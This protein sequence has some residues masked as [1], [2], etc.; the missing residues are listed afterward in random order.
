MVSA[1]PL[2]EANHDIVNNA[3]PTSMHAMRCN[4][5]TALGSPPGALVYARDVFLNVPLIADWKTIA[6]WH[7]QLIQENLRK[8]SLKRW[9]YEYKVGDKILKTIGVRTGIMNWP[10]STCW[11]A[12]FFDSLRP[13]GASILAAAYLLEQLGIP[14]KNAAT[15]LL[16]AMGF[17]PKVIGEKLLTLS[18]W[19]SVKRLNIS[20]S[21]CLGRVM[22]CI[23]SIF[24]RIK[25]WH[26]GDSFHCRWSPWWLQFIFH[27]VLLLPPLH[28]WVC[29][30]APPVVCVPHCPLFC[31]LFHLLLTTW[32][33]NK[34]QCL[35]WR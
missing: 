9:S 25:Y 18:Y 23:L 14:A 11:P 30:L 28:C 17:A 12:Y 32:Y 8:H 5:T 26:L 16:N 34:V 35:I 31:V 3:L 10:E 2:A 20:H 21:K 6:N 33:A 7:E 19:C 13:A 24:A 15:Q 1:I 29:P 22:P 4:V 27:F